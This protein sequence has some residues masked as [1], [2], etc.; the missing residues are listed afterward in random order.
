MVHLNVQHL[1]RSASPRAEAWPRG[2]DSVAVTAWGLLWAVHHKEGKLVFLQGDVLPECLVAV[3][4][5]F[6]SVIFSSVL[7]IVVGFHRHLHEM[8]ADACLF[9]ASVP[10]AAVHYVLQRERVCSCKSC[11]LGCC[12]IYYWI[13]TGRKPDFSRQ[14]LKGLPGPPYN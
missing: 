9:V 5:H 11:T 2:A 8:W 7:G 10:H 12:I 14:Q 3:P 6:H 4:N 13:K 1:N